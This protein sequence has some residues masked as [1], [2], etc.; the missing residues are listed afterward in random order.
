MK[1]FFLF[2]SVGN[3]AQAIVN[4][5]TQTRTQTNRTRHSCEYCGD[6]TPQQSR[7]WRKIVRCDGGTRQ[8]VWCCDEC[9]DDPSIEYYNKKYIIV[10][11]IE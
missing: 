3:K 9:Y 8:E 10:V 5:P 6:G 4:M 11:Q 7:V 1:V 2:Y